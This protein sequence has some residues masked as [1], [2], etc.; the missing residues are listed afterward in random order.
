MSALGSALASLA[1]RRV[2]LLTNLAATGAGGRRTRDEVVES[3]PRSLLTLVPEHGYEVARPAGEGDPDAGD[4][5]SFYFLAGAPTPDLPPADRIVFDLPLVGVRFFTYLDALRR[6]LEVAARQGLP[7]LV[8]DRPNPLGLEVVEGPGVEPGWESEVAS[9]PL[10]LRYG[11]TAGEVARWWAARQGLP[12]P[13]VVPW[14]GPGDPWGSDF[15]APSPN[16]RDL[17]AVR[18]Y[19]ALCL[20]EATTVSEGRGTARPFGWFGAPDLDPERLLAG[21]ALPPGVEARVRGRRPESSK[22]QGVECRGVDLVGCPGAGQGVLGF[23]LRLLAAL[24]QALPGGL[25]W[26]RDAGGRPWLDRLWGGPGARRA[27]EAGAP[28]EELDSLV[29]AGPRADLEAAW[30]APRGRGDGRDA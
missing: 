26:V 1:G 21:L 15:R 28:P 6:L 29:R 4:F 17:A 18:L 20:L 30:L 5:R 19:P 12:E 9:M 10:P 8:L 7:V 27:L 25:E 22:H 23:G 16:L 3:G 2:A 11:M 14:E 13:E 24:G